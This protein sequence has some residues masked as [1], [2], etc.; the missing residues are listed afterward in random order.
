MSGRPADLSTYQLVAFSLETTCFRIKKACLGK[1]TLFEEKLG[2][3][4]FCR[5]VSVFVTNRRASLCLK[6]WSR[7]LFFVTP[8]RR[9]PSTDSCP[10]PVLKQKKRSR[11]W[12]LFYDAPVGAPVTSRRLD[13]RRYVCTGCFWALVSMEPMCTV[14][15]QMIGAVS[16]VT[17]NKL[18]TILQ[19][20]IR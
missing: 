6:W 18:P 9:E 20:V 10:P 5:A 2:R 3:K 8:P 16:W 13:F 17:L 12:R 15:R 19:E 4:L 11:V 14:G 7:L 1:E